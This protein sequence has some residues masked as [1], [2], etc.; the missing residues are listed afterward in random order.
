MARRA[1]IRNR[2][3]NTDVAQLEEM[4][5][6]QFNDLWKEHMEDLEGLAEDIDY[7]AKLLVPVDTGKLKSSINVRVSRSRRYPGIIAHASAKNRGF[8]YALMQDINEEYE[9]DKGESAH[10]LGGTFASNL[11]WYFK[12][13]FGLDLELPEELQEAMDWIE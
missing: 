9:H 5:K 7:D 8:D 1:I 13:K 10:Y 3:L 11:V 2:T 12:S 4:V 6:A